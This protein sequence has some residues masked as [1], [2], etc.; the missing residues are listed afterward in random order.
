MALG[1][2]PP[3]GAQHFHAV[4]VTKGVAGLPVLP[5][6]VVLQWSVV[7]EHVL[8]LLL[9]IIQ[10]DE[11]PEEAALGH[12]VSDEGVGSLVLRHG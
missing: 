12:V 2:I 3:A 4:L 1:V 5:V 11:H 10:P 8:P 9:Q 7:R 6:A